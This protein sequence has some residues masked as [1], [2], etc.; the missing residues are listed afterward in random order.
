MWKTGV[1]HNPR[2]QPMRA[3]APTKKRTTRKA[4]ARTGSA[5]ATPGSA[6]RGCCSRARAPRWACP[7]VA[8]RVASSP[9]GPAVFVVIYDRDMG[10]YCVS[11]QAGRASTVD[12]RP[13]LTEARITTKPIAPHAI[14]P[15]AHTRCPRSFS[16]PRAASRARR[17][18][19]AT[20]SAAPRALAAGRRRRC[21][22][23]CCRPRAAAAR[24]AW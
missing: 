15:W 8:C 17:R 13:S 22:I 23:P 10:M 7:P 20:P 18:A 11:R 21:C 2:P 5:R 4:G 3:N 9:G 24:W 1:C 6:G 14:S 12:R 16:L 19:A